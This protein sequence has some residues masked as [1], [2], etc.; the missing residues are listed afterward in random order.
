MP[1][2][3]DEKTKSWYCKFN[4]VDWNGK[5]RQKMKRGFSKKIDAKDWEHRFIVALK[6]DL[7]YYRNIP[8]GD[9]SQAALY[10]NP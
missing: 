8:A 2:Y 4:Y 1:A 6:N 10:Y 9:C 5:R 7:N 3:Y